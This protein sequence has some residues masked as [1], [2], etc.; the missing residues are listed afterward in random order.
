M[1]VI[2]A[3]MSPNGDMPVNLAVMSPNGDMPVN[4][5]VMSPNGAA[6]RRIGR[7]PYLTPYFLYFSPVRAA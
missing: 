3:V 7:E 2:V 6:Y 4:L 5:A 1:P